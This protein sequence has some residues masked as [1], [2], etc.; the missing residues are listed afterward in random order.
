MLET[1]LFITLYASI[2]S[3]RD[4]TVIA[5]LRAVLVLL[6]SLPASVHAQQ[7]SCADPKQLLTCA[8]RDQASSEEQMMAAYHAL[9]A[10][11]HGEQLNM[12]QRSQV[13]WLAFRNADCT[14]AGGWFA[15]S[16]G[17]ETDLAKCRAEHA[18]IRSSILATYVGHD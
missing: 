6:L 13:A 14:F 8:L 4:G 5:R 2:F 15:L 7:V 11:L 10:E 17:P 3:E 16:D 18:M 9:E 12:L 1:W